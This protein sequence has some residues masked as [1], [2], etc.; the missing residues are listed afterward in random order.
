VQHAELLVLGAGPAGIAAAQRAARR[1]IDVVVLEREERVGGAS[2]SF[3]LAGLRVDHGSHRLHRTIDPAILAELER[4]LGD[5]LQV[6]ERD[7][8]I[9]LAERWLGFPLRAADLVRHLPPGFAARAAWDAATAPFRHPRN[10][11]FAEVVRA[12]LGPTMLDRFYGPYAR[13]LWGEAPEDL[14]GEQARRRITADTP[15]AVLRRVV[16]GGDPAART[17]RYPRR[18]FGQLW[19]A[20]ADDAA[21]AGADVRLGADVTSLRHLDGVVEATTSAG[22]WRA[23]RVLSTVPLPLLARLHPD[24]PADVV[25][26]ARALRTRAMTLVYLVV[27]APRW[28]TFDAHYLPEGWTPVTRISEPRNYRDSADDPADVTVL[29]AE[30][31]C[32]VGD[33]VWDADDASLGDLVRDGIARAGL[34]S[35]AVLE[36]HT[37]RLPSAYPILT[38][39]APPRADRVERWA[40]GLP[41]VVTFGRQGLFVHDNSHHALTMAWAAVDALRPDGS[42]DT[43]GWARSRR[44]F[45]SHVV[46][47]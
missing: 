29:C 22:T 3:E 44:G 25:A 35:P 11:T 16:A 6:R 45:R 27:D 31:P 39:D 36:T 30:I 1:G 26:D 15:L 8:R 34:P 2:A 23:P 4:L 5:D 10:D 46:E 17:F 7:G 19:E 9:R 41:G 47:D 40:A 13:K 14:A 33:A 20:L 18:G 42:V 37:R 38:P 32:G 28:T 21:S 12:Q 24:A 43:A